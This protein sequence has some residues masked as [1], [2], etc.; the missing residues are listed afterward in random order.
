[1]MVHGSL[2]PVDLCLWPSLS[3]FCVRDTAWWFGLMWPL[4][5]SSPSSLQHL[6]V[7]PPPPTCEAVVYVERQWFC[8]GDVELWLMTVNVLGREEADGFWTDSM[9]VDRYG[10]DGVLPP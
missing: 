8:W 5:H 2:Q 1:M 7:S 4:Q 10:D 3:H 9:V 6:P